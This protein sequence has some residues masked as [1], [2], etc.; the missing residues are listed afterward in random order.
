M[1]YGSE[2]G[3]TM[4]VQIIEIDEMGAVIS[5]E[6]RQYNLR[7]PWSWRHHLGYSRRFKLFLVKFNEHVAV[8]AVPVEATASEDI[9]KRVAEE[10]KQWVLR[11]ILGR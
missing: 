5:E 11:E 2:L 3:E 8:V 1:V 9:A 10:V 6:Y 4:S 7:L